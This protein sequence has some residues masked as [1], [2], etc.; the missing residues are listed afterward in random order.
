M[1]EHGLSLCYAC[2]GVGGRWWLGV[3]GGGCIGLRYCI[4]TEVGGEE[5]WDDVL[6]IVRFERGGLVW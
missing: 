2:Y 3:G 5:I 1:C 6:S 4:K